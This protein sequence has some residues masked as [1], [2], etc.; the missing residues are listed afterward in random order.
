MIE[1]QAALSYIAGTEPRGTLVTLFPD[2]RPHVSV[3]LAVVIDGHLWISSTQTRAKTKNVRID[4]RV[5][6]QAGSGP[7][8]A[9]EGTARIREGDGILEDLRRHYRTARGEHPNWDEYDRAMIQDQR[10][11]IDIEPIRAYGMGLD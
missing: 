10:L 7:W 9:I 3:V 8:V 6:F 11:I 4:P 2:G 5:T 1:I